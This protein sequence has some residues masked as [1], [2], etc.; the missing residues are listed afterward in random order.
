MQL[1]HVPI[2][3]IDMYDPLPLH[4]ILCSITF[5]IMPHVM[6][7]LFLWDLRVLAAVGD[8]RV[9]DYVK[10]QIRTM[11]AKETICK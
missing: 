10:L 3:S 6:P 8:S 11:K 4:T 7:S 5:I 9:M 2:H 1:K